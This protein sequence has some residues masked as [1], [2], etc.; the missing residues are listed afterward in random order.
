MTTGLSLFT[1]IIEGLVLDNNTSLALD[2]LIEFED[3]AQ[4]GLHSDLILMKGQLKSLNDNVMR[5]FYDPTDKDY[6]RGIARINFNITGILNNL[7]QRVEL[8]AQV[9]GLNTYQFNISD[10]VVGLEKIIGSADNLF[11]ISWLEKAL[12]ASKAVCKVVR[13]DGE[14]GT[15]FLDKDGYLFT[16]NHVLDTADI[17]AG[18][19]IQFNFEESASGNAKPVSEYKL[20]ASDFK[21]S[22]VEEFDFTRVRVIDNGNIR[23]G[24][25]GYLE[26]EGGAAPA[27]GQ[28]VTIIQHPKG[29]DKRIA[30]R[31]N[32]VLGQQDKYLYYTTDTEPGSSGSPVF[33]QDWKVV[34]L[35]HA[36]RQFNGHDANEGVLFGN[37]L[38]ALGK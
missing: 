2:K 36:A 12:K 27:T 28:G 10:K 22:P 29:G 13:P 24:E 23:L 21:T 33:N 32:E 30:L 38:H 37:I 20:D 4:T 1:K 34:A 26:F 5:G 15:G 7:P 6:M 14:A 18:A 3:T 16:N 35:H 8:Y 17:A 9:R 11:R 31:A 25:W 19:V